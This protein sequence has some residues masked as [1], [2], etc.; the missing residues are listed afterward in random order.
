MGIFHRPQLPPREYIAN[1]SFRLYLVEL[2]KEISKRDYTGLRELVDN[3]KGDLPQQN[4]ELGGKLRGELR[5]Y[6]NYCVFRR[7]C[8]ETFGG[9]SKALDVFRKTI[10]GEESAKKESLNF[11]NSLIDLLTEVA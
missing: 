2:S 6:E 1:L 8:N 10:S 3:F 9:I 7:A 11:V 5:V 4:R